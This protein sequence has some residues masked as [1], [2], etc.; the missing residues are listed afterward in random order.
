MFKR[1][2]RLIFFDLN[3]SLVLIKLSLTSANFGVT[4]L[5]NAFLIKAILRDV[6]CNFDVIFLIS[7]YNLATSF[8]SSLTIDKFAVE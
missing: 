5:W 8:G 4:S 2:K 1:D 7:L 3:L 6:R